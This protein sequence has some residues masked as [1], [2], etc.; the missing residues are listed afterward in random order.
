MVGLLLSERER[1]EMVA[2]IRQLLTTLRKQLDAGEVPLEKFEI[3][4]Q[5]TRNPTE[6][7]DAKSQPH[8]QVA[9]RLNATKKFAYKQGDVVKYVICH[10]SGFW[11]LVFFMKMIENQWV[12]IFL[13]LEGN[14]NTDQNVWNCF[15]LTNF[16]FKF[17]H[18]LKKKRI[19]FNKNEF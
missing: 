6:Y 16:F 12:R 18:F 4:K 17:W 2:D 5:L 14:K 19:N 11:I 15:R 1:D 7:A 3:L 8:V 13:I 9:L 10:V